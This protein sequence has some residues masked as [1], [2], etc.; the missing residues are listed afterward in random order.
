MREKL[1]SLD[2]R[3]KADFIKQDKSENHTAAGVGLLSSSSTTTTLDTGGTTKKKDRLGSDDN[4]KSPKAPRKS[5]K[6]DPSESPRKRSRPRSKTFSLHR[7]DKSAGSSPSKKQK[8]DDGHGPPRTASVDFGSSLAS[9]KS[10]V[11]TRVADA[12][13]VGIGSRSQ[14]AV[15]D[16]F[17]RYLKQ[18][19]RP[20]EVEVGKLHKLR[21]VLRNERVAWVDQFI[22]M[23]GMMEVV[24]L[25]K[26][27]MAV[28]WRFVL[29]SW[30]SFALRIFMSAR[31]ADVGYREEHEDALLHEVLLCLK[32]LCT[33]KLALRELDGIQ[34]TLFPALVSMI[35]DEE[36]KGPSEFTTRGIVFSL[37]CKVTYPCINLAS[38][39]FSCTHVYQS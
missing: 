30:P 16:D 39:L 22:S 11:A 29:P 19:R 25:L 23:G 7:S 15:P 27:I 26:R 38:S 9:S 5:Q 36:K 8:S 18:V 2:A 1:R 10:Q 21:L 35:F 12:L 31:D 3:I 32:A 6:E 37:L 20:Q 4:A 14:P 33:T 13:T 24:G 28:E 17:V 34:S